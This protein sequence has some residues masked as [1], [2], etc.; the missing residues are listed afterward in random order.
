MKKLIL[1]NNAFT[2]VELLVGIVTGAIIVLTIGV[3]STIAL[4]SYKK[5]SD[6]AA[7]YNDLSYGFKLFQNKIRSSKS[8]TKSAPG[9]LVNPVVQLSG[10]GNVTCT[11]VNIPGTFDRLFVS[12][13]VGVVDIDAAIGICDAGNTR[14]L[15]YMPDSDST[16]EFGEVVFSA[17][18]SEIERF[19]VDLDASSDE[20]TFDIKGK[21]GKI[22]FQTDIAIWRRI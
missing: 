13:R 4:S 9:G 1:K 16:A 11:W 6:E 21:K 19:I 3:I 10:A 22:P 5:V 7:I 18:Q 2:L 15:V 12:Y 17:V 14:V 20:A 8:I